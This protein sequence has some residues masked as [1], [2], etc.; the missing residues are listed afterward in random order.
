[1]PTGPEQDLYVTFRKPIL[2]DEEANM[3]AIPRKQRAMVRKGIKNGLTSAL[4]DGVERFFALYADNVH[5]HGTPAMPKRW[6]EALRRSSAPTAR[7]SRQRPRR[8]A[9]EQRA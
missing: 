1:M 8:P 3:L 9:A 5:R 7:C 6:F 4:D 2:P